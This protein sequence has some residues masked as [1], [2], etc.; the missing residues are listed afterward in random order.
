[1]EA[2]SRGRRKDWHTPLSKLRGVGFVSLTDGRSFGG[3][4][5]VFGGDY[6][7]E[8]NERYCFKWTDFCA[9]RNTLEEHRLPWDLEQERSPSGAT[10]MVEDSQWI[11]ELREGNDLLEML[12]PNLKH[13]VIGNS[14]YQT[15]VIS[16]TE[17]EIIKLEC[18]LSPP[19]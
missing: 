16:N 5:I 14:S 6:P 17:P 1:M 11:S 2:H 15:E 9:Y 8:Q 10:N 4:S 13:Y 18:K 19:N 3:L 7:E 12:Q